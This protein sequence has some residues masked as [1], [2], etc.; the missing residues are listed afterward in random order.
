[1]RTLFFLLLLWNSP[2]AAQSVNVR[3]GEH[4]T[5]T[6][7]V[8]SLPEEGDWSLERDE[9]TYFFSVD[10]V[11]EF[12]TQDVFARIRR[13]RIEMVRNLEEGLAIDM[14]CDCHATNF[15]FGENQ[16]VIDINDGPDPKEV[17][18]NDSTYETRAAAVD[19]PLILNDRKN[20]DDTLLP[21][22]LESPVD[23]GVQEI[24]RTILE[25]FS[26]ASAEG[27]I[28]IRE[29]LQ[30]QELETTSKHP[31]NVV[32]MDPA[33]VRSLTA[34]ESFDSVDSAEQN[35]STNMNL[36]SSADL[37]AVQDW[38]DGQSFGAQIGSKRALL[39]SAVDRLKAEAAIDLVKTY[40]HFGFGA[41]AL[42]HLDSQDVSDEVTALVLIAEIMEFGKV[43]NQD[44]CTPE[45]PIWR[46]L[47]D[48]AS[49]AETDVNDIQLAFSNWPPHLQRHLG[50]IIAQ[51]LVIRNEAEAATRLLAM[52]SRNA[53]RVPVEVLQ[54]QSALEVASDEVE[55]ARSSLRS[56]VF[57]NPRAEIKSVASLIELE[58]E[59][60]GF[61]DDALLELAE[62]MLFEASP[63]TERSLL[64]AA[65]VEAFLARNE[66]VAALSFAN[67]ELPNDL[68]IL[69][70]IV[71][72]AV[73]VD[74]DGAFLRTAYAAPYELLDRNVQNMAAERLTELGFLEYSETL[75]EADATGD[76]ARGRRFARA[77]N[78]AKRNQFFEASVILTGMTD[79]RSQ[80]I[81]KEILAAPQSDIENVLETA[82][83]ANLDFDADLSWRTRQWAAL[84]A[85]DSDPLLASLGEQLIFSDRPAET[86]SET[87]ADRR[88]VIVQSEKT[89]DLI[90]QMFQRFDSP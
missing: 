21:M 42:V 81:L 27:L 36:C 2:A 52:S 10:G 74:D 87:L 69:N 24:Q 34:I 28:S 37:F 4:E 51:K 59:L 47:T 25:T 90:A 41:E 43:Q 58:I 20:M 30:D 15:E 22:K 55:Q 62:A 77:N 64:A 35:L 6:R 73:E 45:S 12:L 31:L 86:Q 44:H 39:F 65:I 60:D 89:R 26:R 32:I 3:S 1:M 85:Q 46:L 8:F 16:F 19:L 63:D 7:L 57:E 78:K 84:S 18:V 70:A 14:A 5:F 13:D 56:L 9:Q 83:D 68:E 80:S 76:A 66:P 79:D 29:N 23:E 75:I 72:A 88:A 17:V 49:T 61:V 50:P 48:A 38:S 11:S 33:Q 40:L 82:R 67:R 53:G 54:T 71:K